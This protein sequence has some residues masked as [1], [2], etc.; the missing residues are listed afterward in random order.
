[1]SENQ[2]I[3]IKNIVLETLSKK[4]EV[5][6]LYIKEYSGDL[7][8]KDKVVRGESQLDAI[9]VQMVTKTRMIIRFSIKV[10]SKISMNSLYNSIKEEIKEQL[11]SNHK[12][13][14]EKLI[15]D[16]VNAE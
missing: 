16:V 9:K 15:I 3:D 6:C 13:Y 5:I 7:L 11:I 1:M 8:Y 12:M 4:P 2:L 10:S 14:L